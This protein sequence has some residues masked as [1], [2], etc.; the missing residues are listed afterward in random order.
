MGDRKTVRHTREQDYTLLDHLS[1]LDIDAPPSNCRLTGIICTIGRYF[2][3]FS[4]NKKNILNN[5]L[6]FIEGQ[7]IIVILKI[8]DANKFNFYISIIPHFRK[9]VDG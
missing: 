1:V 4:E 9:K 3:A 6:A 5:L 7:L 8:N 2:C